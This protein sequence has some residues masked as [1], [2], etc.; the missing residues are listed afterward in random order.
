ML[1]LV[2]VWPLYLQ[3]EEVQDSDA[4][5]GGRLATRTAGLRPLLW[6]PSGHSNC[7]PTALVMVSVWPLEL[8]AYGPCYGGQRQNRTVDTRIFSPLLYRL[9]YLANTVCG[10]EPRIK[11]MWGAPVNRPFP[12][13]SPQ[14]GRSLRR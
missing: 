9:S 12:A 8:R 14:R 2:A 13:R 1:G 6:C 10:E 5:F 4:R 3:W 7:G 11:A